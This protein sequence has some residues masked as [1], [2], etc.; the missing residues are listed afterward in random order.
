MRFVKGDTIPG[1]IFIIL[2]AFFM[3]PSFGLDIMAKTADVM[4]GAGFFPLVLS[5]A[6]IILGIVFIIRGIIS[7][8]KTAASGEEV[9]CTET[10][11]TETSGTEADS[12]EIPNTAQ[13]KKINI[14]LAIFTISDIILC[15]VVWKLA[16]FYIA[17]LLM[18]ISLNFIFKRKWLFSIL[19]SV[20]LVGF[21]YLSFTV[22]LG[23]NFKI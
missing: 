23:I 15:F 22:G 18:C 16:G 5:G 8:N 4:P 17:A 19:F 9:N 1:I 21:I 3:V 12:V 6:I 7:N 13:E 10:I 14:R 2:G 11:N 20:I